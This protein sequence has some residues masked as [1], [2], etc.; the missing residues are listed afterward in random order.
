MVGSGP[1]SLL[2]ALPSVLQLSEGL[3]SPGVSGR[4]Q[5][6]WRQLTGLT[7]AYLQWQQ[8]PCPRGWATWLAESWTGL[9]ACFLPLPL[10]ISSSLH[11]LT[12]LSLA[13][14]AISLLAHP[15]THLPWC[16]HLQAFCTFCSCLEDSRSLF[17]TKCYF[18]FDSQHQHHFGEPF[19]I[20]Q[21]RINCLFDT[22]NTSNFNCVFIHP[23]SPLDYKLLSRIRSGSWMYP[24][25]LVQCPAWHIAGTWQIFAE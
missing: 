25:F 19:L 16:F 10:T 13:R 15:I 4:K 2:K 14:S 21:D 18:S 7:G 9:T 24:R 1:D 11:T 17:W 23:V 5:K 12:C 20:F 6:G 3:R 8:L 22:L